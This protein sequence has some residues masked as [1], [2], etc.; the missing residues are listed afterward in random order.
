MKSV[1]SFR[2]HFRSEH[3]PKWYSGRLHVIFNF[4]VLT[5]LILF[6]FLQISSPSF[7]ELLMIPVMLLVGNLGVY[8][9][10]RFPLHHNYPVIGKHTYRVHSQWHHHFYTDEK[11]VYETSRDFYILFFPPTVILA[12]S[13]I[14]IPALSFILKPFVTTNM[15][16]LVLGMSAVYFLLYEF[17]HY[18]SHLEENHWS[19][20]IPHLKNMRE[21]HLHHHNPKLMHKYNF[22][23]VFPL[24]DHLFGTVYK[25]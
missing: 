8:L 1:D 21:H 4:G 24:C 10:H 22:N 3:I 19:L 11:I 16:Y 23:I 9:I 5:S 20:K 12:F 17:I 6:L 7:T 13:M 25:K 18:A 2:E 14:Y 15:R